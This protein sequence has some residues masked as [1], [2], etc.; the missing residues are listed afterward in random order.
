MSTINVRLPDELKRQLEA[1]SAQQHRP[2]ADLV[3][4]SLRRYI[5][6]EQMKSIRRMTTPLAE[7]QGYL[8][9]EDIFGA[10]S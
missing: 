1:L 7:A 8:T 6:A 5:A 4:E 9:D 2:T 10:I 3:R